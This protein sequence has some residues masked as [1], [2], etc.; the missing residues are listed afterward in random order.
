MQNLVE[1]L[2][3]KE[4]FNDVFARSSMDSTN[5]GQI[6]NLK[7]FNP[8]NQ[9]EFTIPEASNSFVIGQKEFEYNDDDNIF[10]ITEP[11]HSNQYQNT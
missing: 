7:D 8:I 2:K 10:F 4:G 11:I 9:Q 1:L 3:S 6:N 5:S